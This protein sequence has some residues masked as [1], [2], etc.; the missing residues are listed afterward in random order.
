[1]EKGAT[2]ILEIF[3]TAQIRARC[4]IGRIWILF[5]IWF[6]NLKNGPFKVY[7]VHF[8]A[9]FNLGVSPQLECWNTG[10]LGQ[11]LKPQKYPHSHSI[12]KIPKRT[13]ISP[14]PPESIPAGQRIVPAAWQF[15]RQCVWHRPQ[16]WPK[17]FRWLRTPR[18]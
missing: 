14:H 11:K 1:M 9:S 6:A 16:R 12:V 13:I 3:F 17:I 10:G 7:F 8:G 2:R 18:H 5:L 4:V 15:L